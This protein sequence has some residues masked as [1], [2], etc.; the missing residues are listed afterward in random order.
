[1][2]RFLALS[3]VAVPGL[4]LAA[5]D[6]VTKVTR[7]G[8]TNAQDG[9]ILEVEQTPQSTCTNSSTVFLKKSQNAL[10]SENLSVLL[11]AF[12]ADATIRLYTEGCVD[13]HIK[14]RSVTVVR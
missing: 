6:T 13:G 12:H 4:V 2:K 8:T 11:S 3:L 1:M 5:E 9:V 7:V 10:F 14:F